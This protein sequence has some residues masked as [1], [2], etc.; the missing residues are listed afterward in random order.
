MSIVIYLAAVRRAATQWEDQHEQLTG[1][2][3]SLTS[4]SPATLGARVAGPARAFLDTWMAEIEILD[5]TSNGHATALRDTASSAEH[6][7]RETVERTQRLLP[8][9]DRHLTPKAVA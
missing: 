2:H 8:W 1:A 4:A 9:D 5:A 6:T 3:R 7:D